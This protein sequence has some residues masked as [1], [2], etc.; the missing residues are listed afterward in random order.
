MRQAII[1]LSGTP[2]RQISILRERQDDPSGTQDR[3]FGN[4]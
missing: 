4:G 2:D 1:D 3:S